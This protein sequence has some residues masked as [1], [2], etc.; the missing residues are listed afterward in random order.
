MPTFINLILL[1]NAVSIVTSKCANTFQKPEV[2]VEDSEH[3][4]VNWTNAFEGCDSTE[5]Q[6][7]VVE[8]GSSGFTLKTIRVIDA[9]FDAKQAK[10]KTNPCL[11]YSEI[12]IRLKYNKSDVWSLPSSYNNYHSYNIKIEGLYSGLLQNKV[13]DQICIKKGGVPSIPAIPEELSKCV[14][15]HESSKKPNANGLE[16]SFEIVNPLYKDGRTTRVKTQISKK[17][18][19]WNIM[20]QDV[21]DNNKAK[22]KDVNN[23]KKHVKGDKWMIGITIGTSIL[24]IAI[25]ITVVIA[26]RICSKKKQENELAAR[27]DVNPEYDGGVDYVYDDMG[28]YESTE[29]STSRRREVT[30]ELVDRSSIYGEEEEGWENAVAVDAN[31][32]Y[33]D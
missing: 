7:I 15:F 24:V 12:K 3:L 18:S 5:V 23:S 17:C 22:S 16:F 19:R 31:S 6:S 20:I 2:T 26:C 28:N 32:Y 10:V 14:S 30:A 11:G 27:A 4:L 25:V 33:G 9:T 1:A 21:I 29:V 8:M 13:V